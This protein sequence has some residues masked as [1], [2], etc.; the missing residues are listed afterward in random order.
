MSID[1]LLIGC[2]VH[3]SLLSLRKILKL[4]VWNLFVFKAI[5][6]SGFDNPAR[7]FGK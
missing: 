1:G 7:I 5:T 4:T 2:F 3:T 6:S